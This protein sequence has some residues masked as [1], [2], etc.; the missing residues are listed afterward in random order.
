MD[1]GV[2]L[3]EFRFSTLQ[4]TSCVVFGKLLTFLYLYFIMHKRIIILTTSYACCLDYIINVCDML[5]LELK[6]YH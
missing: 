1:S 5:S 4:L 2:R 6:L 3:T